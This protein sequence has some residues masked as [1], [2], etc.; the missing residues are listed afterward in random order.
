MVTGPK[1]I[2]DIN[3]L[4]NG[5]LDNVEQWLFVAKIFQVLYHFSGHFLFNQL[6][7]SRYFSYQDVLG[8]LVHMRNSLKVKKFFVHN[9]RHI[10]SRCHHFNLTLFSVQ[11][12]KKLVFRSEP[13]AIKKKDDSGADKASREEEELAYFF[14]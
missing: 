6:Q 1:S 9:R 5:Y 2:L 11:T 10:Y 7:Q 13:P 12:G 8:S 4:S 14:T 3:M